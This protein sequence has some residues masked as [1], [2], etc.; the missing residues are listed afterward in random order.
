[1]LLDTM[2]REAKAAFEHLMSDH[3][4]ESY[5]GFALFTDDSVTGVD[6]SI[7]TQ[8]H[9]GRQLAKPRSA[10]RRAAE[11]FAIR[12]YSTEWFVEGGYAES[13]TETDKEIELIRKSVGSRTRS[14]VLEA[15]IGTL[16]KLVEEGFFRS[17]AEDGD[18][19]V[20]ASISDSDYDEDLMIRSI[21]EL[22]SDREYN[23]FV[24]EKTASGE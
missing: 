19:I 11:E 16:K 3:P 12:W 18:Y 23:R 5:C 22:N 15:M 8:G 2:Y 1:M 7:N 17:R 24:D 14:E 6:V 9:V 20:L 10:K 21:R 4:G 13:F